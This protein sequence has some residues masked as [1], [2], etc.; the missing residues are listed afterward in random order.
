MS[1]DK[2]EKEQLSRRGFLKG[3]VITAASIPVLG[4]GCLPVETEP[5]ARAGFQSFPPPPLNPDVPLA[6]NM[7]PVPAMLRTFTSHEAR[8]VE[9]ITA[10]L[11]PGSAE[12]PGARE[13]GVTT[14]I[15]N[16]LAYQE[17]FVES[18][19]RE[20]PY[21]ELY[22]GDTPPETTD[23]YQTVWVA[24][25]Q[26]ERYGYQSIL[27]PRE[28]YRLGIIAVDTYARSRYQAQFTA[29]TE[30]QQD[31][32]IEAMVKGE[33]AAGFEQIS[34]QA[35]FAVLRRHTAEGMFSDPAYGGN[36]AMVGWQ[37][38]GYPGAQRAYTQYD[39]Q[40][41]ATSPRPP[42]SLAQLH[43]FTPGEYSGDYTVLPVSGSEEEYPVH[44]DHP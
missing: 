32:I 24:T 28:V 11:M 38:L 27:S 31:T 35:F 1:D 18:T 6:P 5:I 36:R 8:T 17:G 23:V 41:E 13:A 43:P 40:T 21:A 7:P 12:D 26:I 44:H 30:E 3:I 20:P 25:D 33:A 39:I 29:L 15:D 9:A 4:A 34:A 16:M 14:Y 22:S 10:R 2:Y 37:L 42:Q 19:Y